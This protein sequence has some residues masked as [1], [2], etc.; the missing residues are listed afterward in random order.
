MAFHPRYFREAVPNTS[1][2]F[3]YYEWNSG[4]R[5][6]AAQHIKADARKQ[7][8]AT[9]AKLEP[10]TRPPGGVILFSAA[11]LH[12]TVPNTSGRTRS[13][14][15]FRTVNFTDVRERRGAAN[16]DLVRLEPLFGISGVEQT[17]LHLR[18]TLSE[19]TSSLN[20]RVT[21]PGKCCST[22]CRSG[23]WLCER[24]T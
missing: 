6:N 17:S 23:F 24:G 4:G 2:E 3:R 1:D 12:S 7:P 9:C 20:M 22:M 16:I 18:K 10:Q 19:S 11:H 8:K 14:I 15:G 21:E 5:K 13:S